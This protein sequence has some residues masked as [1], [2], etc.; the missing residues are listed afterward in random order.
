MFSS[1]FQY[2]MKIEAGNLSVHRR[3]VLLSLSIIQRLSF[4]KDQSGLN[5]TFGEQN[6]YLHD[7]LLLL[8]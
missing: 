4:I 5:Q 2:K 6:E 7:I 8:F 1:L 3:I